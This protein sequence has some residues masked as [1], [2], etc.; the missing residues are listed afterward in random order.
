M[1]W[2][3]P[4]KVDWIAD[5][6]KRTSYHCTHSVLTSSSPSKR[7]TLWIVI[8]SLTSPNVALLGQLSLSSN[9]VGESPF[10]SQLPL[11]ITSWLGVVD[12]SKHTPALAPIEG[13]HRPWTFPFKKPPLPANPIT[14]PDFL[15]L[16][17]ILNTIVYGFPTSTFVSKTDRSC[18]VNNSSHWWEFPHP[19]IPT[20]MVKG[21]FFV[22]YFDH[23]SFGQPGALE[24]K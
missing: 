24:T 23:K 7:W 3:F 18:E 14:T 12:L 10:P 4:L 21:N 20:L 11:T 15:H 5:E 1:F 22:T 9:L 2:K 6:I 16:L 8:F 19:S 17:V 13:P